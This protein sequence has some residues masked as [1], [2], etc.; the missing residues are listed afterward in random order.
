MWWHSWEV[1]RAAFVHY[2]RVCSSACY[3]LADQGIENSG[4][5]EERREEE[6]EEEKAVVVM[7]M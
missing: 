4:W 6:E 2:S 1:P 5:K 7:K 3:S